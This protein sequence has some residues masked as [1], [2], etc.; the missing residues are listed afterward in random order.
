MS[1][2]M[3]A[4]EAQNAAVVPP[5]E[6][7]FDE[8]I[9]RFYGEWVLFQILEVDEAWE[10]MR[11]LVHAHSQDRAEISRVLRGLPSQ[12]DLAPD[13]P[14]YPYYPFFARAV[15]HPNESDEEARAR[16]YRQRA[17][18]LAGQATARA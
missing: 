4:G 2:I 5:I 17:S 7:T 1:M 14:H 10:P 9:A 3:H 11:G 6:C 15:V 18:F 8:A 16:F 12:S 13:A